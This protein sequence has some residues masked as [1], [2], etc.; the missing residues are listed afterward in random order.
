MRIGVVG[1]GPQKAGTT[2]LYRSLQ[3]HPK[4]CF[5]RAVK[6]TFFLDRRFDKGWSWYWSHF[7][8]WVSEQLCAEIAPSYFDV[9]IVA[10]RLEIHNVNARII[11]NLRDPADRSF[12]LYLHHRRRGRLD[13]DFH[14][15][16]EKMP[17]IIDSSHYCKHISRWIEAFGR[18]QVLII[19]LQ[20]ISSS[21]EQVLERVYN[22]LKVSH[23]PLPAV[24][25]ERVYMA[26]LPRFPVLAKLATLGS[27]WLRN[28]RLYGPLQSAKKLGLKRVYTGSSSLP[29]LAPEIR[30][31]LIQEFKLDIAYVEDLLGRSLPEWKQW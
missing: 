11:I 10:K 27:E 1:V 29:T 26:S 15:A 8:H 31:A 28:K 3:E 5:P 19:L 17:Q 22:F 13:C 30:K 9:P 7:A 16:V 20:N 18:E 25:R 4:L 6:E 12:S 23:I 24:A 21:P 14:T 2:W